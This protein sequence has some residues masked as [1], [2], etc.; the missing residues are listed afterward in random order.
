M[1]IVP[2]L[3]QI[4]NAL[5]VA[6]KYAFALAVV[7]ALVLFVP[8]TWIQTM[9]LVGLRDGYRAYWWLVL[10]FCFTL[11]GQSAVVYLWKRAT[12]S[13]GRHQDHRQRTRIVHTRIGS[14]SE[15]EREI[16][17]FCLDH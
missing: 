15:A 9:G 11:S 12:A 14:L 13:L 2:T 16:I 7:A 17:A 1:P 6:A 10:I 5:D 3:D 4:S 8:E